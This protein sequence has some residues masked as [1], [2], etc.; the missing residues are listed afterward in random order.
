MR[1]RLA[2]APRLA[3]G[4]RSDKHC[5]SW[6]R[7]LCILY[8]SVWLIGHLFT[9][10]SLISRKARF[11]WYLTSSIFLQWPTDLAVIMDNQHLA[12][13]WEAEG[14][15][16]LSCWIPWTWLEV[17]WLPQATMHAKLCAK[18]K[19][20]G[21]FSQGF[22]RQKSARGTCVF[23]TIHKRCFASSRELTLKRSS[24][25]ECSCNF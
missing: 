2:L 21:K 16:P 19:E 9:K 3:Y 1:A 20:W 12:N 7:R 13:G 15:R 22:L 4:W 6:K 10:S 17:L 5:T 23:R 18:V 8:R 14:R 24:T 11:W 25:T